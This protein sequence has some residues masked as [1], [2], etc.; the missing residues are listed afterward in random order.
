MLD[1]SPA[2]N[3]LKR[4]LKDVEVATGNIDPANQPDVVVTGR[5]T[6]VKDALEATGWSVP[7]LVVLGEENEQTE[8]IRR[9][10]VDLGLPG[11][12]LLTCPPG[13]TIRASRLTE[14]IRRAMES[15]VNLD[16]PVWSPGNALELDCPT[17]FDFKGGAGKATLSVNTVNGPISNPTASDEPITNMPAQTVWEPPAVT[18]FTPGAYDHSTGRLIAVT[19]FKRGSGT[20]TIATSLAAHAAEAGLKM[21]LVDIGTPPCAGFHLGVPDAAKIEAPAVYDTR[22]G[23]LVVPDPDAVDPIIADLVPEHDAIILNDPNG[24]HNGGIKTGKTI[25]V[26]DRGVQAVEI[27]A[28][29]GETLN[30]IAVVN[31]SGAFGVPIAAIENL[32]KRHLIVVENDLEGCWSALAA[33]EPALFRSAAVAI[34]IGKIAAAIGLM[35]G[36]GTIA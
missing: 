36:G 14:T 30:G 21:A 4:N 11:E 9:E 35:E 17:V 34:G 16:P 8:K 25:V 2:A 29:Y 12:W 26:L 19:S 22:W 23:T 20:T 33:G 24:F 13:E 31:K 5:A 15:E 28:A 10:L 27:T 3:W 32:L 6:V 18:N 1:N 7:V